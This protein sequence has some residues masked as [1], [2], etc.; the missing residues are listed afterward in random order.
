M[1]MS[2]AEVLNP[3]AWIPCKNIGA[4][5]LDNRLGLIATEGERE[6]NT[7]SVRRREIEREQNKLNLLSKTL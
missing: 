4:E 6:I 5:A 2:A 7:Q 3:R 1:L